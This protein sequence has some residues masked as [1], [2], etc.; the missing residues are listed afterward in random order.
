MVFLPCQ[1]LDPIVLF[2]QM[3]LIFQKTKCCTQHPIS[4]YIFYDHLSPS[5]QAF[6]SRL[7]KIET[8]KN[9][10]TTLNKPE[11]KKVVLEEMATLE[12]RGIL[13]IN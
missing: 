13:L 9:I 5:F 8:L 1:E 11:W 4:N 2:W 10:Y 12:I 7:A 6:I 3:I